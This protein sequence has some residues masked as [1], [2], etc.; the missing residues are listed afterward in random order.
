MDIVMTSSAPAAAFAP[1]AIRAAAQERRLRRALDSYPERHRAAV[2]TV[3]AQDSRYADLALSFPALLFVLAVPH[4]R[5][6]CTALRMAVRAGE[7]LKRLAELAGLP[8]WLRKLPPQAFDEKIGPLPRD[9]LVARQIGNY[10]PRRARHSALWLERVSVASRWGTDSFA[11]WMAKL[12][13]EDKL[14]LRSSS[15]RTLALWAWFSARPELKAGAICKS[16][17]HMRM[18]LKPAVQHANDWVGR[19]NLQL[20]LNLG[21]KPSRLQAMAVDGFEFVYLADSDMIAEEAS[22]MSNC[23]MGYGNDIAFENVELWSIRRDGA[24]V[25]TLSIGRFSDDGLATITEIKGPKNAEVSRAA[26]LAARRWFAGHD[27]EAISALR[28][29]LAEGPRASWRQV[30]KPYWLDKRGCPAWPPLAPEWCGLS[31]VW[32]ARQRRRRRR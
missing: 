26:A 20:F 8:Y 30:L 16:P 11:L 29:S 19:F 2:N 31:S 7:P 17:W 4:E 22:R 32:L 12:P 14:R 23:I 27:I 3:A 18:T 25:A 9:P 21:P 5:M 24:S 15:I 28:P 13:H 10:L 6:D 1:L